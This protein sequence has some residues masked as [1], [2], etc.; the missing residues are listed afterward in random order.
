MVEQQ[1]APVRAA[2]PARPGSDVFIS[3][4]RRDRAVV[5]RLTAALEARGRSAWVD[6][7]D[8]PPTAE[9]MAEIK[10]AIDAAATIVVVL[11]PDSVASPVCTEELEAAVAANKRIVP[12]VV[13]NVDASEVPPELAKRNWL[14]LRE[15]DD[16]EGG[17]NTLVT[18]LETDLDRVRAHSKLLV[19]TREW[20]VNGDRSLLLRGSELA[21][22]ESVIGVDADPRAT[23]DQTRF[24]V[25]SR[26]A[27]TRRQ[28][29]VVAIA[30]CVALVAATL[31]VFA[32]TQ[33]SAAIANEREAVEQRAEAAARAQ[34][35]DSRR[36]AV[37]ALASAT[38]Q[39][40]LAAA[41]A[42]ESFRAAPT[43]EAMDAMHVV[44]QRS[45]RIERILPGPSGGAAVSFAPDSAILAS[46]SKQGVQM[47]DLA[48]GSLL[49][50]PLPGS[51]VSRSLAI[52]PDGRFLALSSGREIELWNAKTLGAA[53][54]ETGSGQ[55]W[56]DV[57]FLP[58]SASFVA[59]SDDAVAVWEAIDGK[60]LGRIGLKSSGILGDSLAVD[61]NGKTLAVAGSRPTVEQVPES[62]IL[63]LD[64]STM[65]PVSGPLESL[66][67]VM[68][69][70]FSA[71]GKWLAAGSSVGDVVLWDTRTWRAKRLSVGDSAISEVAFSP[72]G[73]LLAA[74]TEDGTVVTWN[75]RSSKPVAD[76]L[77]G[78]S[79]AIEG[80]AFDPD[81]R[82]IATIGPLGPIVVW[83]L[84]GLIR[85]D[86]SEGFC[87]A[88]FSPD[89]ASIATA[90]LDRTARLWDVSSGRPSGPILEGHTQPL[91]SI[92]FGADG[93]TVAA[94]SFDGR[95][96]E[97]DPFTGE[98]LRPSPDPG[99]RVTNA[100]AIH[101]NGRLLAIGNRSGAIRLWDLVAGRVVGELH[102]HS[103]AVYSL[104]FS[105][106]G[107]L[108]GS[109]GQDRSVII[110]DVE[111]ETQ[112]AQLAGHTD[113]V[114][115]VA[116][117]PDGETLASAGL[118]GSILF[119]RA[120]THVQDGEALSLPGSVYDIAFSPDGRTLAS[121]WADGSV[122]LWDIE[123]RSVIGQPLSL[124]QSWVF[125]VDFSPDGGSLA[126]AS[127]DGSLRFLESSAWTSDM[128]AI[129]AD[130][131]AR[132]ARSL[133]PAEWDRFQPGLPYEPT[134]PAGL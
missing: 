81:G 8:I 96:I 9:W 27:A 86:S 125:D 28:R 23:A 115:S 2:E 32:W 98:Q 17:V 106:D 104:A 6:F 54:L 74:G 120:R 87:C 108:L 7:A 76:T 70:A 11:S 66:E 64:P 89:G 82:R 69:L 114:Y 73:A 18:T 19:R 25:A 5:E 72:D 107:H 65:R 59:V 117:A 34:V 129:V 79:G 88:A 4:S 53:R 94:G 43:P 95:I 71:D 12:V 30:V 126:T 57:A 21:E 1:Q 122:V 48:R 16:F 132:L 40:D 49:G 60:R 56:L 131:C 83:R 55:R 51:G 68:Q 77:E 46:A 97:W 63:L 130:L 29:S 37:L 41:L 121:G 31:G 119:W 14:F 123:S 52:S 36:L 134:C 102:G 110:W 127:L 10:G 109:G 75:I 61:P 3:Y 133:T 111:S 58:D 47:W 99:A 22:A 33:R 24:V 92:A 128:P 44:E 90:G 84:T 42:L 62:T 39:L 78:S 93:R 20:S 50:K 112:I 118:D 45:Q 13:R 100:L 15:M 85:S 35:A 116:F 101:P 91:R 67:G 38:S 113:W 105:P 80:I 124:H 26:Q 103:Q